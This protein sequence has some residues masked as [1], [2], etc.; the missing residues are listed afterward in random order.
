MG[1]QL[2]IKDPETVRLARALAEKTGRTVTETIRSALEQVIA[3]RDADVRHR[4]A[5]IDRIVAEVHRKDPTLRDQSLEDI[6]DSIYDG[7]GLP[8]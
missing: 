6:M 3:D 4:M 1:V 7:D 5:E 8:G 2:N